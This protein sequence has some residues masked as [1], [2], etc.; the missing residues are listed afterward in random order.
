MLKDALMEYGFLRIC[1][2]LKVGPYIEFGRAFDLVCFDD[3]VEFY[4]ERCQFVN[5]R[6]L[7]SMSNFKERLDFCVQSLHRLQII[8]KDIKPDNIMFSKAWNDYVLVD[9]GISEAVFEKPGERTLTYCEGTK[10][11]M[12]SEMHDLG[13]SAQGY[14]DLYH[15]DM[16]CLQMTMAEINNPMYSPQFYLESIKSAPVYE[17]NWS[18]AFGEIYRVVNGDTKVIDTQ[19]EIVAESLKEYFPIRLNCRE[20]GIQAEEWNP[21]LLARATGVAPKLYELLLKCN[22]HQNE[23]CKLQQ[24]LNNCYSMRMLRL[25][26]LETSSKRM[27]KELESALEI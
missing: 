10:K 13:K 15:N 19:L 18:A 17:V 2:V 1:S 3:C 12:S 24:L 4:M 25:D 22:R 5:L 26:I 27:K 6:K 16:N 23:V 9:F 11:Y 21:M 14:A 20:L 7:P 8:H